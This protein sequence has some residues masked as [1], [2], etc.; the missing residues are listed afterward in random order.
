MEGENESHLVN[1]HVYSHTDKKKKIKKKITLQKPTIN[2]FW[3]IYNF[4]SQLHKMK[5]VEYCFDMKFLVN[6]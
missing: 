1:S 3:V 6:S 5:C 4:I 2:N